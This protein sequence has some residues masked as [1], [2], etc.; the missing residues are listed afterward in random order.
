M[1]RMNK[2]PLAK[3]ARILELLCIVMPTFRA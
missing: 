2:L 3:R 1:R